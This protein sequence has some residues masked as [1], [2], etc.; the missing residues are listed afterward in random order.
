L[1]K[2]HRALIALLVIGATSYTAFMWRQS[3]SFEAQDPHYREGPI[4]GEH[5]P[6]QPKPSQP[7]RHTPLMTSGQQPDSQKT[8]ST[9]IQ[10]RAQPQVPL[11]PPLPPLPQEG[12]SIKERGALAAPLD[13]A[14]AAL[15]QD[16][17]WDKEPSG[18]WRHIA[19]GATLTLSTQR[20]GRL[21]GVTLRFEREGGASAVIPPLETLLLG[22]GEPSMLRWERD[23]GEPALPVGGKLTHRDTAEEGRERSMYY[24]CEYPSPQGDEPLL[25][26]T[27]QF[28]LEPHP[29]A[30]KLG[31]AL[32]P[33][34]SF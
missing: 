14:R 20:E 2:E 23:P 11:L 30:L 4:V 6:P 25:P 10:E 3:P 29:Q 19:G 16:L 26:H 9:Q 18:A 15:A 21:T 28:T 33:I 1:K 13:L 22:A 24:Y 8:Q 17:T 5:A 31:E 32:Q 12:W 7:A 27:C 34:P